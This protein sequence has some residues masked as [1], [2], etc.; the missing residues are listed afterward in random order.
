MS[1]SAQQQVRAVRA[2]PSYSLLPTD[3]FI[4][5]DGC[6]GPYCVRLDHPASWRHAPVGAAARTDTW[7]V[8]GCVHCAL[9]LTT[10]PAHPC[11]TGCLDVGG[12]V[13]WRDVYSCPSFIRRARKERQKPTALDFTSPY[14]ITHQL[15]AL[16]YC[17]CERSGQLSQTEDAIKISKRSF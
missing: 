3:H 13:M 7:S 16:V 11:P 17:L 14:T 12:I 4:D 5:L 6:A 15:P 2:L 1:L 9:S 8:G 10:N